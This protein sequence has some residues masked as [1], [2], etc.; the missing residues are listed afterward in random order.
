MIPI[1]DFLV[2]LTLLAGIWLFRKPHQAKLG[3]LAA[4]SAL[5][6]AFVLVLFRDRIMDTSTVSISLVGGAIVGYIL[7]K[8]I[9]MI[10]I[11][12]MV[13]LQNGTGGV[14]ALL[15]SVVELMRSGVTVD[16]IKGASGVIG[17]IF[18]ALTFSGSMVASAKLANK[19]R[20]AP[21]SMPA[22]L[23]ISAITIGAIL[24][25]AVA[26]FFIPEQTAWYLYPVLITL[27]L[28][29]GVLV[30]IRV[31]GADMP[32]MISFLNSM[33]GLAAALC[34]MALG[35]RLLIVFGATVAASGTIL[36]YLMCKA[37]NRYLLSVLF[38]VSAKTD[39]TVT[40]H[41][42]RAS[43]S[44]FAS[45]PENSPA[46]SINP[47]DRAVHLLKDAQTI[48]F[49]PGYGMALAKAQ[50]DVAKLAE[51]LIAKGKDVRYAIHPVAGRMPGHMN[52]LLAEA[53]VDY[54]MLV[55][56]D[57]INSEF[58]DT[59]LVLVVGACDVVNPA[60]IDVE[61]T[62][63]SGMPVLMVHQS[64][65]VVCCNFDEKPGYSGVNNPLYGRNNTLLI[66]GDAK[67]TVHQL[68]S[69]L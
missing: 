10:Q 50:M 15:V 19:I 59:D 40:A 6:A 43:A 20:Q 13:A 9:D 47:F 31:G 55:E 68:V 29:S 1:F 24:V 25:V 54:D 63:I 66:P 58:K 44:L 4:A 17:L 2:I 11:P 64:K 57:E 61:G 23:F 30:S 46:S 60:A 39:K 16:P 41:P 67:S 3:N 32:V 51:Q 14:A 37:M 56:M 35:N 69:A 53:G 27:A 33:T 49:V 42:S 52:V 28:I 62:P 18:G 26:L 22:H 38:P 8:K 48:I 5:L 36:T 45:A 12:A 34:G 7:A 21:Y 65:H